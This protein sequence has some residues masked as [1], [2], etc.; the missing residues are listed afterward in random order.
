MPASC[1]AIDCSNRG[2]GENHHKFF[3]IP[4]EEDVRKK[5][6]FVIRRKDWTPTEYSRICNDHFQKGR[7]SKDPN[8]VD[9]VPSLFSFKTEN[10]ATTTQSINRQNRL[11]ERQERSEAASALLSIA[12]IDDDN[13][14]VS[15]FRDNIFRRVRGIIDSTEI[16]IKRAI[17]NKARSQPYS[18]YKQHNT[19]KFLI[20]ISPSGAIIFLSPVWGGRASDKIINL[21]SGI[22]DKFVPDGFFLQHCNP[23]KDRF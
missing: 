2:P 18:R 16:F 15:C 7:P 17:N 4:K 21:T 5:W 11:K 14:P 9:Y 8:D 22:I 23:D 13:S 12:S 6:I 1:C 20:G 19:V 3:R 10:T